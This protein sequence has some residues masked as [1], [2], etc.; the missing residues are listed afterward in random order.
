MIEN[1]RRWDG[2]RYA[3]CAWVVMPNHVH[4]IFRLTGA[5]TLA[6]IVQSWKSY[7]GRRLPCSWQRDYWDRCIRDRD[8]FEQ[9]VAY[10]HDNPVKA[11]LCRKRAEWPWSSAFEERVH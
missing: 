4:V 3:L 10:V 8:H 11:G 2:E 6:R 7:T 5:M 1:W 9:A